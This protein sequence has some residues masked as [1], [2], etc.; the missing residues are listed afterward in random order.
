[1]EALQPQQPSAF[2]QLVD[3]LRSKSDEELK[4]LYMRFFDNDLKSEWT[5]ITSEADFGN[6]TEEDIVKAIKQVRG[7]Q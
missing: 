7:R 1:M 3:R 5:A 4:T 6:A 2:A